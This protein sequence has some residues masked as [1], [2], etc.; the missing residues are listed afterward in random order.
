MLNALSVFL[1][2]GD[3]DGQIRA[4]RSLERQ[5]F[6][7]ATQIEWYGGSVVAWGHPE[8]RRVEDCVVQSPLGA[9]CCVGPLWFRGYFGRQALASLLD[10]VRATG[11]LEEGSLRGNFAL[12][13]DTGEQTWLLNDALGFIRI[14]T[15]ADRCFFSTSWL[16]VC[17]Y[18]Q[19]VE[20][21]AASAIEYVLLGAAH[22][23]QSVARGVDLLPLGRVQD[24]RR[25]STWQ[26]FPRG[27]EVQTPE[28]HSLDEAVEAIT[29]H[30][31]TIS[32]EVASAF[33]GR[34]NAA[35]SGGFDSRLIV[36]GLLDA[37]VRPRLFVY[38]DADS[39]DVAAARTV[40]AAADL[41]LEAI[42]KRAMNR[43]FPMPD[44]ESLE[45]SALFF[46]G[47]PSDGIDDPGADRHTRLQQTADGRIALNGGGGE[48]FR[49]FFHLPNR[50]FAAPDIVR[51]FYRGFSRSVFRDPDGLASYEARLA[52]SM[53]NIVGM[54][55]VGSELLS[56]EQ[57]E[58]LYPLFRCHY[59][60]GL[61]NSVAVRHGN[62]ATPLVDLESVRLALRVPLRWKNAGALESRLVAAL[63]QG[64]AAQPSTY[65]FRFDAGPGWKARLAEWTTCARP[66]RLRPMINATRRSLQ[67]M[68]IAPAVWQRYRA[69]L[70]GEWRMDSLLDLIQLADERALGRA[71]AVEVVWRR[72]L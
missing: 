14:Y 4:A 69:L 47:L 42:D 63:H 24:F 72:L 41:A 6:I 37:G 58:L 10:E 7:R 5:R 68:R 13:L 11:R 35:L 27:F 21:D 29:G 3:S 8:Q 59:W 71:L 52:A 51:T 49:N 26:R 16:A 48:I 22:S 61:N 70:P 28:F 64:V 39:A 38:G 45:Q 17:A 1:V 12:F 46:D 23:C 2:G 19:R 30:L 56:R 44:I 9:A 55:E 32:S 20:P 53:R 34:V 40:A 50:A 18:G 66:V 54:S 36:A 57:V 60:M 33:P 43:G 31:R 67:N 15:S 25:R 62:Y 65:G